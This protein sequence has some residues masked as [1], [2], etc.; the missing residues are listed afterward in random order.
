MPLSGYLR[1]SHSEMSLHPPP[2]RKPYLRLENHWV[3]LSHSDWLE[4]IS[5]GP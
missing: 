2:N 3:Y 4:R 1:F 5:A